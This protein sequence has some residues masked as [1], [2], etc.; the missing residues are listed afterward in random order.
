[1]AARSSILIDDYQ[2][3]TDAISTSALSKNITLPWMTKYEFD[4]LIGLRVM[5]LSRGAQPLV[6]LTTKEESIKTNMD[7]R[8]VVL[9]EL[10]EGKLPYIIKRPLPNG[11]AEYWPVEKLSLEAVKYMMR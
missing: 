6:A 9:K 4:Q 5:H 2:S 8:A 10:N 11:K 3:I 7:L 1:M